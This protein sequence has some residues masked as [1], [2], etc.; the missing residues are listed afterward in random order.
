M[1]SLSI[2]VTQVSWQYFLLTPVILTNFVSLFTKLFNK[3]AWSY[4]HD[5]ISFFQISHNWTG[6]SVS[7]CFLILIT[8][9]FV[10]D[11]FCSKATWSCINDVVSTIQIMMTGSCDDEIMSIIIE[12][13]LR[14]LKDILKTSLS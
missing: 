2:P 6:S 12:D 5:L 9:V 13:V 7:P 10:S 4:Y 3:V 14:R 1:V 11:Y 8:T